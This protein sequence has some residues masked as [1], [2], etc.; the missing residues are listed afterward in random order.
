MKRIF[1]K[2][3][4]LL[5]FFA[6]VLTGCSKSDTQTRTEQIT[7]GSWRLAAVGYDLNFDWVID[8]YENLMYDCEMDNIWTFKQNN[9]VLEDEGAVRCN[10]AILFSY[11]WQLSSQYDQ[12]MIDDLTYAIKTLDSYTLE[13]YDE[14]YDNSGRRRY[15]QKWVR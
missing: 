12:I 10:S 5:L 6:A 4:T 3:F 14:Y 1:T 9:E 11:N 2:S 8:D 13:V 7:S 15:I